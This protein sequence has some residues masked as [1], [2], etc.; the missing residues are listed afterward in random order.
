MAVSD[1]DHGRSRRPGAEDGDDRTG[2]ILSGRTVR[3]LDG[4]VCSL[5]RAHG[6]EERGF[7]S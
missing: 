7:L 4:V 3:R 6:D 1:G 2:Q 5:H